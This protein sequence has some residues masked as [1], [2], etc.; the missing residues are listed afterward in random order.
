MQKVITITLGILLAGL[1]MPTLQA[2]SDGAQPFRSNVF[3]TD[4]LVC[5]PFPNEKG[6]SIDTDFLADQGGEA[7]FIPRPGLLHTGAATGWRPVRADASGKLDFIRCMSPNQANVAYAAA[8]IECP[9]PT[10]AILKIGSNDRIKIWLNGTQVHYYPTV[11][12]SGPDA[13]NVAVSLLQGKNVLLAK[14]DQEG[15]GWFMYA[16][17]EALIKI[18]DQLWV[19]HP[20]ISP[21]PR[22]V[23]DGKV[24]DMVSILAFNMSDETIGPITLQMKSNTG[25]QKFLA[26][27]QSI[28]PR[29]MAWL[30]AEAETDLP[31]LKNTITAELAVSLGTARKTFKLSEKR[32]PIVPGNVY[33]VPGFHVDPVWVD[34]QAGFQAKSFSNVDQNLRAMEADS[35]YTV[36]LHEIPYIKPYYDAYP[37][38]R[39]LI[40]RWVKQGRIATGGSYN[41]PNETT[42]SG[43]ALVRNIL[44]GRLF[45]E[46]VLG[47]APAAYAPWDVFGHIIQMPQILAKSEF[48]GTAWTR[49]NYREPEVRV[50]DVPD[51]Y[52]GVAPDGSKLLTRKVNY[53]F[54]WRGA[55]YDLSQSARQKAASMLKSQQQQIPGIESELILDASDEK[56]PTTWMIGRS[57]EFKNYIPTVHFSANGQAEYFSAVLDQLKQHDLDIPELSRDESQYNEGCELSRF[58]L[59]MGNRLCENTL[60]TAEKFATIA[61]LLGQP[62]P[63]KELDKAWRQVLYGQHHDAITGCG[64]DVPYL[65]L[66]AGYREALQLSGGALQKA[67]N[68]I[69]QSVDTQSP[70]CAAVLMVFN[71]LNWLRD[72]IVRA[73]LSFEKPLAGFALVDENG[74]PVNCVVEKTEKN[75]QGLT[76]A[77]VTFLAKHVPSIGYKTFWLQPASTTPPPALGKKMAGFTIEND[78]YKVTVDEKMGGG[79]TSLMDKRSG[80]ELISTQNGHPGNE[81]ILLKEGNGF[82]PAWRFITTGEKYFSK[83]TPAQVQMYENTLYKRLRVTGAMPRLQKRIQEIT[84]Y[85][86]IDRIDFRTYLVDY[87]GLQGGNI[88]EKEVHSDRDFYCIGFPTDL[89]G[90]VPVLEDRFSVK[91]Y[92]PSKEYLSYH[93]TSREWTSH[94]AMNSCYQWMDYGHSV[95][96]R[97]GDAFSVAVGPAE[98]L[99][100]RSPKLRQSGFE[101]QRA[102]ARKGITATPGYDAVQRNY[103]IQYRRFSFSI[104]ALG[105]NRYN[106]KLLQAMPPADR[107]R[108][109]KEIA[110][111]GYA[112]AV[113]SD[114]ALAEAWF[115]LPVLMII[116]ADEAATSLAVQHLTEQLLQ[117]GEI[118]LPAAA[119]SGN[120]KSMVPQQGLAILNRGNIAGSVEAEGSMIL[121]LFHAVPWQGPLLSWTHD[122]PERKTHI[123]DYSLVPHQGD[124]RQAQLVR[125]GYEF[126]NPLI[127]VASKSHSGPLPSQHSFFSTHNADAVITAIKPKSAGREAF[128]RNQATDAA[129]GVV[130]R[131][132]ETHGQHSR[133]SIQTSFD[134]K[135][136]ESVNLMERQA[137]PLA[138]QIHSVDI[139]LP[140][141]SIETLLLTPAGKKPAAADV[142]ATGGAAPAFVRFWEHNE[143]AAPTGY[144]PVSVRLLNVADDI[145]RSAKLVRRIQVAITND[146]VD[147]PVSGVAKI[148]APAGFRSIP[149]EIAYVVPANSEK[150]Y[151][152][153]LVTESAALTPGFIK[154][155]I[156]QEGQVLYD[157]LEL[158][159]PAKAFGHAGKNSSP[160]IKLEWQ[161]T[162]GK[163]N[164]TI[165]L[166]NTFNQTVSGEITLIAPCESWGMALV[167]PICHT[168][169]SPWQRSFS[170]PSGEKA[171]FSFKLQREHGLAAEEITTWA[172]AKLTYLGYVEYIEAMGSLAIIK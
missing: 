21:T 102:L 22:R 141:N 130:L 64:A 96:V 98:I 104:G 18:D 113:C 114:S 81:L 170:L 49:S 125:H 60:V 103:D 88:I 1:F 97:C 72:D 57:G 99:T 157:I 53:G 149:P 7:D 54:D 40:R 3:I 9:Q 111:N 158:N 151:D 50:P 46:N 91:A 144:L 163:D 109:K 42:I 118:R 27:G 19:L 92:F 136:A 108:I 120:G 138:A 137:K 155:S 156:E 48:I 36:F 52:W 47:D 45:H 76:S 146:Y 82:E 150:I 86:G 63:A 107:R 84:L 37:L 133:I 93:S 12:S 129:N 87:Q 131:F 14:V 77:R 35:S 69:S 24:A 61:N 115:H 101:L 148:E 85:Q 95:Q 75:S 58:D 116:G 55:S 11:R 171:S 126:N 106:E 8:V 33:L 2:A 161:V 66:N 32:Q 34:S 56:A 134:L 44:Y 5:G 59:K 153:V 31:D 25:I 15:A 135:K 139:A 105:Q 74:R 43:E 140:A 39:P 90:N 65:D 68:S 10:F 165:T 100:P 6:Q 123:F 117:H 20:S 30:Q 71:P 67:L 128:L 13:D 28:E 121:G 145:P 17:L 26:T 122:F 112:Y 70:G 168:E 154:A 79:I 160:G 89:Q 4:W 16:R 110:Q 38:D 83:D 78:Q 162:Q 169:L 80:K 73:D 127:A 164:L 172:V 147:A 167:N 62:Y 152:V 166:K 142:S 143:G 51:L 132:Y 124:W 29:Q 119:A 159:L 94:H 23:N 41:Q